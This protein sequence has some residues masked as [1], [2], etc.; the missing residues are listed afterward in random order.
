[1]SESLLVDVEKYAEDCAKRVAGNMKLVW[2]P[3][4]TDAL[5]G[6]WTDEEIGELRRARLDQAY[7]VYKQFGGNYR[8]PGDE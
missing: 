6:R 3:T 8:R 2:P 5:R 1:M 7:K 4:A